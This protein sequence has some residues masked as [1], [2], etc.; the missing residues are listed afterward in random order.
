LLTHTAGGWDN[1]KNDPM[2]SHPELNHA[3]LIERTLRERPLDH[4]P[5]EVFAYSNFGYCL[6]GR[7]IEKITRRAYDTH[8]GESI[9]KRCGVTDMAI[10]GNT[11]AQRQQGEVKYY[12][13]DGNPYGMNVTRMDSHGGWI[14]RAADLVQFLMRVDGF[15]VPPDILKP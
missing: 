12:G 11:L 7:V 10:A 8:V 14:A 4:V 5:G 13:Q 9:L 6:L 3:Q 2:F 1:S 15:G